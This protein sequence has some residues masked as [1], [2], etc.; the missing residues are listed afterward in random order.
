MAVDPDDVIFS[1]N[2]NGSGDC[3]YDI[4]LIELS[5]YKKNE[6][7]EFIKLHE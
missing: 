4:A 3:G 6:L 1:P 5:Q 7:F 2:Y